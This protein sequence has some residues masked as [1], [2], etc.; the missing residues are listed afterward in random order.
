MM[1][2]IVSVS[3]CRLFIVSV[4]HLT[5]QF[6]SNGDLHYKTASTRGMER[7]LSFIAV[8][9]VGILVNVIVVVELRRLFS[10]LIL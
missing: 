9:V 1:K 6:A 4:V 8:F 7:N 10:V 2:D 5:A 3:V